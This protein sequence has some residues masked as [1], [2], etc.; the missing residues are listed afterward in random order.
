MG[1]H[2]QLVCYKLATAS[3]GN[4]AGSQLC[5]K[6]PEKLHRDTPSMSSLIYQSP[7]HRAL[8]CPTLRAAARVVRVFIG[9]SELPLGTGAP[10]AP[11]MIIMVEAVPTGW[12]LT[13]GKAETIGGNK[14]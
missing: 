8:F 2:I 6:F 14:G 1:K 13:L 11:G 10:R 5:G 12:L 3:Q 9:P 7:S 4:P